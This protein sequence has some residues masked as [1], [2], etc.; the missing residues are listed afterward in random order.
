VAPPG[1]Q[2]ANREDKLQPIAME[3]PGLLDNIERP[4]SNEKQT[5]NTEH[6]TAISVFC[7]ISSNSSGFLISPTCWISFKHLRISLN[8][9][10]S[11]QHSMLDVRCWTFIFFSK[12]ST[13]HPAQKLLSTYG[14]HGITIY[15]YIGN[16]LLRIRI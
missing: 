15:F 8:S 9:F 2:A 14:V 1:N 3:G 11:I 10:S 13:V 16:L 4:T 5:S 6:S 12:P 7:K